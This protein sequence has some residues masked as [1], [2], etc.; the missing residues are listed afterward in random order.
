MVKQYS[1]SLL[2]VE[3]WT[4]W[5]KGSGSPPFRVAYCSLAFPR[6]HLTQPSTPTREPPCSQLPTQSR[7]MPLPPAPAPQSVPPHASVLPF[8]IVKH[9]MSPDPMLGPLPSFLVPR[10]FTMEGLKSDYR[11]QW[12]FPGQSCVALAASA[13]SGH[14]PSPHPPKLPLPCQVVCGPGWWGRIR[15]LMV[16]PYLY[17]GL[18]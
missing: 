6:L 12:D 14:C 2:G 9:W 10:G 7:H 11:P 5:P 3:G 15:I 4:P 13:S 16:L 17:P 8:P 18:C 1:F